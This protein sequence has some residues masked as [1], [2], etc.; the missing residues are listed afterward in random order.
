MR[1]NLLRTAW[2]SALP[3]ALP[4]MVPIAAALALLAPRAQAEGS[5][6]DPLRPPAEARPAAPAA[7]NAA[8]AG[9]TD[10]STWRPRYLIASGGKRWLVQD[11]RRYGVGDRFGYAVVARIDDDAVWLREGGKTTRMPL[12]GTVSKRPAGS[13][14][15]IQSAAAPKERQP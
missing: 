12:F 10:N 6:R 9:A 7:S 5:E 13:T 14:P 11:A 15:T 2:P 8:Q 4:I 3:I 1:T